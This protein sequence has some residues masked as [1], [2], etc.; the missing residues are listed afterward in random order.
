MENFLKEHNLQD[1][2]QIT[3][4]IDN[5]NQSNELSKLDEAIRTGN[6]T[7]EAIDIL[8]NLKLEDYDKI[9]KRF[10]Q[11]E[12]R[13]SNGI[14]TQAALVISRGSR[15]ADQK[16]PSTDSSRRAKQQEQQIE[17]WAKEAGLWYNDYQESSDGSLES[18]LEADGG[19]FSN[20]S[21]SESL[22]YWNNGFAVKAIDASHYTDSPQS[23]LDKIILHNSI[24][25][26][27]AYEVIGFGRDRGG[28]FRVIAKQ[29]IIKGE[30]PTVEDIQ[31]L[32]K[33]LGLTKKGGWYYTKDGK[34]ITDLSPK[35]VIKVS[36]INNT[37]EDTFF[38]IDCDVEFTQEY[39]QEQS[40][41]LTQ[42]A[43]NSIETFTTP[44]GE[45]FGFVEKV[46]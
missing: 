22:V 6:W 33:K 11:E 10:S 2:L 5:N 13:K 31:K 18:V 37:N 26:E 36:A 17:S 1:L 16:N 39:L 3:A 24:F 43:N 34:R 28:T 12:L 15:R 7:E 42:S 38:V 45:V 32:A 30:K 25:P 46:I 44:Q 19:K 20:E 9:F 8:E 35:N 21:G 14:L 41:E 4:E 29:R 27:T 40:K 23:L